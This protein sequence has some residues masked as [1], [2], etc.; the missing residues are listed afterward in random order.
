MGKKALVTT[1]EAMVEFFGIEAQNLVVREKF[2]DDS[3]SEVPEQFLASLPIHIADRDYCETNPDL[4]QFIPYVALYTDEDNEELKVFVYR[5]GKKGNEGRL[6]DMFSI[7]LGGHVEEIIEG[8]LYKTLIEST[9][10]EL[11]EEVNLTIDDNISDQIEVGLKNAL[12]LHDTRTP[13]DSVHLGFLIAVKVTPQNFKLEDNVIENASWQEV[14]H[15]Q[16]QCIEKPEQFE[17]WTRI[18]L[19]NFDMIA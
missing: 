15:L 4:L 18:F 9:K 11:Q 19:A 6:H 13:V 7:G 1:A 16:N 2:I 12:V 17:N 5:R 14:R 8:D 3:K 10:R